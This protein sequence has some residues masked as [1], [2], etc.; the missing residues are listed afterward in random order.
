[1]KVV[2]LVLQA[3]ALFYRQATNATYRVKTSDCFVTVM[4]FM[5]Q[6]IYTYTFLGKYAVFALE[7]LLWNKAPRECTVAWT[8]NPKLWVGGSLMMCLYRENELPKFQ[9][10]KKKIG[11]RAVHISFTMGFTMAKISKNLK[12]KFW[13]LNSFIWAHMSPTYRGGAN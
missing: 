4:L 3:I 10:F 8:K 6:F 9:K 2:L 5:C 7:S 12:S 11:P 1:M 13:T